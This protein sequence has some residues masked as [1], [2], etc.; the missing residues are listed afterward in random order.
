MTNTK[1]S[2]SKPEEASSHISKEIANYEDKIRNLSQTLNSTDSLLEEFKKA[3]IEMSEIIRAGEV[4]F[5]ASYSHIDNHGTLHSTTLQHKYGCGSFAIENLRK[6]GLEGIFTNLRRMNLDEIFKSKRQEEKEDKRKVET[7]LKEE[8]ARYDH[9][10]SS[11]VRY[12]RKLDDGT[13]ELG[14][15]VWYQGNGFW[16]D[17]DGQEHSDY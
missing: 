11:S 9:D 7:Q 13:W 14:C 3:F 12:N 8:K 16:V 5:I 17:D 4:T 15:N 1:D 2:Y 6:L 10:R